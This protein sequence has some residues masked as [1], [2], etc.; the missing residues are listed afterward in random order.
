M[1][2]SAGNC[3]LSWDGSSAHADHPV[4]KERPKKRL[5]GVE[6]IIQFK[7]DDNKRKELLNIF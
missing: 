7:N 4:F 5:C 2:D 3:G 6:K 1:G